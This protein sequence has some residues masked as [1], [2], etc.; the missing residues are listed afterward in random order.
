MTAA[1]IFLRQ[2][3]NG[4]F[5]IL[6]AAAILSF[7][8][9]ERLD[10][11]VIVAILCINALLGFFQEYRSQKLFEKFQSLIDQRVKVKRA[12][13]IIVIP[14]RD[15]RVGNT[16]VVESGDRV[17]A[18]LVLTKTENIQV[19][20]SAL[21]GESFPTARNNGDRL[22]MGTVVADG[23]AEGRVIALAEQTEFG[24]IRAKAAHTSSPSQFEQDMDIF[25]KKLM[26][27]VLI[28]LAL[29]FVVHLAIGKNTNTTTLLLFVFALAIGI[30]PEAM[31][32]VTTLA[33]T[34]GA[35]ALARQKVLVKKLAAV[36]DLGNIAV[37]CTDKTGTLTEGVMSVSEKLVLNQDL[38]TLANVIA[39]GNIGLNNPEKHGPFD[40]AIWHDLPREV[41]MNVAS[42]I[43]ILWEDPFD[44]KTRLTHA[45]AETA[46]GTWLVTRGA[47]ESIFQIAKHDSLVTRWCHQQGLKGHRVLV[48]AAKQIQ[49]RLSYSSKDY[50]GEYVL[51][52]ISFADPLKKSALKA[53]IDAKQLGI[54]IKLITGDSPEVAFVIGKELG[55]VDDQK[56]VISGETLKQLPD[57]RKAQTVLTKTVFARIFPTQKQ[58]IVSI[59]RSVGPV[60]FIGDGVNDAPAL[61]AATVG[62]AADHA[63]DV[64]REA[65]SIILLRKD[66]HVVVDGIRKGRSIFANIE[67]Y[68]IFT[69]AGD[70][71]TFYSIAAISLITPFLPM[72]PVQILLSNLLS[73]L[74]MV[75]IA[76]DSVDL[77][78]LKHPAKSQ[79]NKVIS[80]SLALGVISSFFDFA[81]FGL[82]RH[83]GT[84]QLQTLWFIFSVLTELALI[85]S[86]RSLGWFWKATKPA[87]ILVASTLFA[88]LITVVIP[89]LPLGEK[90]FHF[91]APSA[92]SWV[93][94]VVLTLFY[95]VVT[96]GSKRLFSHLAPST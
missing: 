26:V 4:F 10:T 49:K 21:T 77:G 11:L 85:F 53:V 89:L 57:D 54:Q 13:H 91:T 66:L 88:T 51:G 96:E 78:R 71:G 37:L 31:P 76:A 94:L 50:Q 40:R 44:P 73:D 35:L 65:A 19:D 28:T 36:E 64:A 83:V 2:F 67:K 38:F 68:L 79:F 45:V 23:L 87:L 48:I 93:I 9:G 25:S 69:L 18:D 46:S 1:R 81:F 7:F 41:S 29:L 59:L 22:L 3:R 17:P 32:L 80:F 62:I 47:P 5:Y 56:D 52:A 33:M 24:K 8:L 27:L 61:K 16:V 6:I 95:F 90:F 70:F 20:E 14:L 42:H 43:Q 34:N 82:F 74:P 92:S 55:L 63:T 86:I 75:S 72:L 12:G 58:E 84:T 39:M 15:L 30:V 60:G